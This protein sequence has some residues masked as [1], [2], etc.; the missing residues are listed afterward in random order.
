[1]APVQLK[2]VYDYYSAKRTTPFFITEEELLNLD[3]HSF[4]SRLLLEVPHI[5][6]EEEEEPLLIYTAQGSPFRCKKLSVINGSPERNNVLKLCIHMHYTNTYNNIDR[7]LCTNKRFK[8][9]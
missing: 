6:E 9:K 2:V 1:M 8:S 5:E 7:K 4:K 3:F